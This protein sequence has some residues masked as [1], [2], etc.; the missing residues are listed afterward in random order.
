[1]KIGAQLY[2]VK[3]LCKTTQ[4]FSETLHKLYK[5]GYR[6]VQISAINF[7]PEEIRKICGG[8][9]NY[10]YPFSSRPDFT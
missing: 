5:I 8:H 2:T 9:E 7:P 1:M 4:E 3:D 6:D 10:H